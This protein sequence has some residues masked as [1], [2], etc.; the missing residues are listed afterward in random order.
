MSPVIE[1]IAGHPVRYSLNNGIAMSEFDDGEL[2][3]VPPHAANGMMARGWAKLPSP[4]IPMAA[5]PRLSGAEKEGQEGK[6]SDKH[7]NMP[8]SAQGKKRR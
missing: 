8:D 5:Q 3:D 7:E 6:Q 4:S 2:Y 1:I